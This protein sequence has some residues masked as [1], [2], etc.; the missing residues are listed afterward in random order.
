MELIDTH[1]HIYLPEFSHDRSAML[2]RA[3][4]A[5]VRTMLLPNI[6]LKS[7]PM[8]EALQEAYPQYMHL[9]MGLHPCSVTANFEDILSEMKSLLALNPDK[10]IAIGEIGL[11]LYWDQSTLPYQVTALNAQLKWAEYFKKPFVI[12]CRNAFPELFDVF[13]KSLSSSMKGVLHC[14]SGTASDAA[15]AL[16]MDLHLGI[17]GVLTYKKSDLKEILINVPIERLV[18]ETDAPYLAPVPYRGKRNEPAYLSLIVEQLATVYKLSVEEVASITT[19][20]A[21]RLFGL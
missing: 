3:F 14:F 7:I 4:D 12:H 8:M 1:T 15:C 19:S 2:Q 11:D 6:D 13:N 10:Y 5:D 17:G 20:N 21:K 16:E 9:M 18:L